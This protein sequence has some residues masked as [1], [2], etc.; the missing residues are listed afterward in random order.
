MTTTPQQGQ[1]LEGLSL[2]EVETLLDAGQIQAEVRV[3]RWWTIR[4]NGQTKL[5]KT[6]PNDFRIPVKA[7][8]KLC[9]ELTPARLRDFRVKV[10]GS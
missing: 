3:G 10:E 1:T 5:W 4:R 7:G 9:G 8:L 2:A 6:R